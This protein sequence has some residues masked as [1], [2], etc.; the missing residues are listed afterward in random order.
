MRPNKFG[1]ALAAFVSVALCLAG[2]TC[3][4][5]SA[6]ALKL[7]PKADHPAATVKVSGSGF[8]G[9]EA[10]DTYFDTTDEALAATD[11]N[12]NFSKLPVIVPSSATPG[13]HWITGIGRHSG[14]SAQAPFTVSTDWAAFRFG[15]RHKGVNIYENV[16]GVRNV[17]GLDV[18]W[19]AAVGSVVFS[20]PA[21]AGGI[22]YV[23]SR[24]SNVHAFDAATGAQLWSAPTGYFVDSSPAVANGV[25]YVGS[26][27]SKL[28]A[29]DAGTGTLLWSATTGNSIVSSPAVTNGI[30]S[31]RRTRSSMPLMP[32]PAVL[33]GAQRLAAP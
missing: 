14:L 28:Y 2:A 20:S 10:V 6:P 26:G 22:V 5:A 13:T 17:S 8:G 3:A 25:V 4:E 27:D 31:D 16:L 19:T 30:V 15:Q 1:T 21:V 23:G 7:S 32:R 18:A 11:L 29:F 33:C 9:S 12:G 24:D